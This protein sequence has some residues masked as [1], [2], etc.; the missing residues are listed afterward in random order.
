M[1]WIGRQWPKWIVDTAKTIGILFLAA[2]ISILVGDY[3][4][5]QFNIPLIYTL[6]VAF[7]SVVTDRYIYGV[8]ASVFG[9][10]GI[11]YLFTYPYFALDFTRKDYPFTFASMLVVALI[12]NSLTRREKKQARLAEIR[13]KRTKIS[14]EI[15]RKLMLAKSVEEILKLTADHISTF[16]DCNVV[17]Y[18]QDRELFY[19]TREVDI[20]EGPEEKKAVEEAFS[21]QKET[22]QC[23][24][25]SFQS[26]WSFFPIEV[27]QKVLWVL[28]IWNKDEILKKEENRLFIRLVLGQTALALERQLL[29]DEQQRIFIQAEKEKMRSNLLRAISHDLRTPLTGISGASSAILENGSALDS[30]VVKNL[31]ENIYEDSQW[32]IRMVENLLSVTRITN[33]GK[34]VIQK[35]DEL[36]EEIVGEAVGTIKKRFPAQKLQ[37]TVP[38]TVIMVPMDGMLIEQV[39]INLVENAILHAGVEDKIDITVTEGEKDIIFEVS[40]Y[41]KGLDEEELPYLLEGDFVPKK[42]KADASRGMGIGLSLCKT[43]VTAHGGVIQAKN[44]PNGG[45]S[46]CFTIPRKENFSNDE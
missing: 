28:G 16:Y 8:I 25:F 14:Y 22:E 18:Q 7:I 21:K 46:F 20:E 17:I 6:A 10:V 43:I 15:T 32:L 31:I 40:D 37:V 45:A 42:E 4:I 5:E 26:R 2:V 39:I 27:R 30:Q 9:I 12:I 35:S 33:E 23:A 3:F 38:E 34:T 11:N 24:N 19:I 41:G 13:E 1:K 29:A 36:V 44:K